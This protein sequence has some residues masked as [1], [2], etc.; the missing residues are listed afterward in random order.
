MATRDRNFNAFQIDLHYLDNYDGNQVDAIKWDASIF[1]NVLTYI[2]GLPLPDK[3]RRYKDSWLMYL[4]YLDYDEHYIFGRLASAEYG[5]TGELVHADSLHVRPNPKQVREGETQ[6][7]YF[8]IRKADGLLLM[9]GNLRLNRS[10]FE[11]YIEYY[12][13][14]IIKGNSLTYIQI[15][16]LVTESFF[17]GIRQ[18]NSVN[19]IQIEVSNQ[20]VAADENEAVRVLQ[21]EATKTE[22]TSVYLEFKAKYQRSG[23][24]KVI[25]FVQEYKDKKGV[26]KIVVKGNL[27]GASK[28][29]SLEASQERYKKRVEVDNNNQPMLSSVEEVLREVAGQRASLREDE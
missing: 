19:K 27:G 24:K 9:Q 8:L 4:D 20:E 21:G 22:S 6:Y 1:Q 7:T 28:T 10:K 2:N 29:I 25:P 23:L 17:E 12:G 11:E 26:T 14:S 5:T 13:D 15:C 3:T 16:T 18:L